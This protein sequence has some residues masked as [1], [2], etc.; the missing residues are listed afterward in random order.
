MKTQ[1]PENGVLFTMEA[2][3]QIARSCC[4]PRLDYDDMKDLLDVIWNNN[5][6]L[7]EA[8]KWGEE[9]V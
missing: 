2:A 9:N 1:P 7:E 4:S 8:L 6:Q 3:V 5:L